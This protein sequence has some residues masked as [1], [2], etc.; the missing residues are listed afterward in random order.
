M[1]EK[2]VLENIKS[3]RTVR[4]F[5]RFAT[6]DPAKL[7]RILEAALWAPLSIYQLQDWK[8]IVLQN[9]AR[10]KAVEI[11]TQ[12]PTISKYIRYMYEHMPWGREE[13]WADRAVEFGKTMGDAPVVII[14]LVKNDHNVHRLGHNYAAAWCA[15]QNMMLQANAEGLDS[16]VISFVSHKMENELI[17]FL[18]FDPD[19]WRAA[20][21]LNIGEG[22]E[23]PEPIPRQTEGCIIFKK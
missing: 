6:I 10:D 1:I 17:H 19:E 22:E 3:R 18:G 13:N 4:R 2:H 9:A 8:F 5:N 23:T 15:A 20:F 14:S 12:D 7:N 16:G 21:A 11:I